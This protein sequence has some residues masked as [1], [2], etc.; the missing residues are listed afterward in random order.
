M[1]ETKKPIA[2]LLVEDSAVE[3]ELILQTLERSDYAVESERVDSPAGLQ[4]AMDEKEWDIVL[5]DFSMP[6]F[7]A[8]DALAIVRARRPNLPLIVVSGSVGEEVAVA[9][10]RAGADDY[11]LKNNLI[12]LPATIE[13]AVRDSEKRE[14]LQAAEQELRSSQHRFFKSFQASPVAIS[15]STFPAGHFLDVNE[16]FLQQMG[17]RREDVIGKTVEELNLW[18]NLEERAEVIASLAS[19]Q[20]VRAIEAV[21]RTKSGDSRTGLYSADLI[22]LAGEVC[23]LAIVHDVTELRRSAEAVHRSEERYRSLV[24]NAHDAIFT[25][26]SD[27]LITSVNSAFERVTGWSRAQW[28][29]KPFSAL[30]HSDDL[31]LAQVF[32]DRA[33]EQDSVPFFQLRI[34]T[35]EGGHIAVELALARQSYQRGSRELL[36]IGRD[37]SERKRAEQRQSIQHAVTRILAESGIPAEVFR[38][39]L[40]VLCGELGW[41]VG[42]VWAVDSA[43]AGLR[44][45][46]IWRRPSATL[47]EFQTIRQE[48]AFKKGTGLPGRVWAEGRSLFLPELASSCEFLLGPVAEAAGLVCALGCP[49]KS[50]G[51]VLGVLQFFA[52]EKRDLDRDL[53]NLFESI[54]T[55]IGQFLE[56]KQ[57]EEQFLQAQKLEAI[58]RLAGGVAHDF[59]NLLTLI[60]GHASSLQGLPGLGEEG[61][62]SARQIL[63]AA[64]RAANLTR[65]LLTF[66]RKQHMRKTNLDLNDLVNQIAKMFRRVLGEDVSLH[67][68]FASQLPRIHAD[69]TML[70]QVIMNLA[71]NARDAMLYGGDLTI[72]TR[73]VRIEEAYVR[74]HPEALAGNFVCLSFLDTGSGIPPELIPRIFE[75]FFTTKEVGQG[76]GLGLATVYGIVKQHSGWIEVTSERGRGTCFEIFF[77]ALVGETPPQT[78]T[79]PAESK[80]R[81]GSERILVVED[82]SPIRALVK[83]ILERHG[84]VVTDAAS[85]VDALRIWESHDGAFDLLLTDMVLPDGLTGEG[86]AKQLVALDPAL[87]VIYTSGYPA[88][89]VGKNLQLDEGINYLQKPYRPTRLLQIVRER[90]DAKPPPEG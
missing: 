58:G 21:F 23:V 24:E 61:A 80:A 66:S 78:E 6:H 73:A 51:D 53:L 87:K 8:G 82:E 3:A 30:V 81:R 1:S 46:A 49:I 11:L 89:A 69:Q 57:I 35:A 63:A 90:L 39:V 20:P 50:R 41:D 13:R 16:A 29:D 84:Y 44:N 75:P 65:Q 76:T 88:D 52:T 34:A 18:M 2:V 40:E 42:E 56:R 25:I 37:I 64:E 74:D 70:E 10:M 32:F 43:T 60:Q 45:A 4:K 14:Q 62:D 83:S 47:D 67:L 54:G 7:S 36:G 55:Q 38:R 17:F 5:A 12:R 72:S 26:S 27:G 31:E 22:D 79:H 85:G 19:N 71:V 15:I 28:L 33:L 48:I 68:N 9:M 59:N 77:P 86:L